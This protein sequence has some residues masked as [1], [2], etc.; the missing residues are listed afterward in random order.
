MRSRH[1]KAREQEPP[2]DVSVD[3]PSRWADRRW[4]VAGLLFLAGTLLQL[5]GTFSG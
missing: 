3:R 5:G 1:V 4:P 2:R